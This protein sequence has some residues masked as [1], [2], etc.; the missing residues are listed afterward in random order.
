LIEHLG[1][2]ADL[3]TQTDFQAVVDATV[4][5]EPRDLGRRKVSLA[6]CFALLEQGLLSRS[7]RK[8][9]ELDCEQFADF[10]DYG[11]VAEVAEYL[12]PQDAEELVRKLGEDVDVRSLEVL[13]AVLRR[14]RN[15]P[16]EVRS[17]VLAQVQSRGM[18]PSDGLM[19]LETL[20]RS[21][22]RGRKP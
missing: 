13:L 8:A 2:A 12:P 11:K 18:E 16:R 22:Q 1:E 14:V 10:C 7:L 17:G 20:L 3:I 9:L 5:K 4:L 15:L 21:S 6:D 19:E